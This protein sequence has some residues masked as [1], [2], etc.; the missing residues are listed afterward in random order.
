MLWPI[1][2]PPFYGFAGNKRCGGGSLVATSG[3]LCTEDQQVQCQGF[4][5]IKGLYATGNCCGGRFPMGYNGI[6]NG[7]SIGQ[8]LTQGMVLGEFLATADLDEATTLGKGNAEPKQSSKGMGPGGPAP[9]P[10]SAGPA[11]AA[12]PAG[13]APAAGGA[14]G[15]ADSAAGEGAPAGK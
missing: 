7:V 3:L 9:A 12:G 13:P 2:E 1:V 4:E 15:P 5:P 14:A 10:G 8:A 11:P 6:M